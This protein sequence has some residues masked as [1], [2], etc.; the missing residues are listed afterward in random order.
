[1][2]SV[3]GSEETALPLWSHNDIANS[4]YKSSLKIS[5]LKIEN[6][7]FIPKY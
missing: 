6:T 1:M 7:K 4:V 5:I 3:G 2:D